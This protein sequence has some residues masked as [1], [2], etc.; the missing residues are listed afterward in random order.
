M[1]HRVGAKVISKHGAI[2]KFTITIPSAWG[3]YSKRNQQ[4]KVGYYY[5]MFLDLY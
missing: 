4:E 1:R 5:K 3:G 2:R